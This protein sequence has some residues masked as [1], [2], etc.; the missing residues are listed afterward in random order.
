MDYL[1]F[2]PNSVVLTAMWLLILPLIRIIEDKLNYFDLKG[3]LSILWSL[4]I[5]AVLG[6]DFLTMDS[7]IIIKPDFVTTHPLHAVEFVM[8]SQLIMIG[9]LISSLFAAIMFYS[10]RYLRWE[11][12]LDDF[13][14]YKLYYYFLFFA[15]FLGFQVVLFSNDAFLLFVGWELMVVPGYALVAIRPSKSSAEAGIKYALI[16]SIGSIFMLY[17]ISLMY[18]ITGTFNIPMIAQA[19]QNNPALVN[20]LST[21]LAISFIIIGVGVTA[22]FIGFQTWIPDAYGAATSPVGAFVSGT[23]S[24][25]AMLALAKLLLSTLP[26]AKFHYSWILIIGGLSTMTV[27]NL[28]AIKQFGVRRILGY[29][30]IAQRGYLLFGLGLVAKIAEGT[31][32]SF[33][34]ADNG[35]GIIYLFGISFAY[36]EGTLFLIVGKVLY[37]A[38]TTIKSRDMRDL[39]GSLIKSPQT[40]LLMII[41]AL[42]LAGMPPTFGFVSK[43]LLVLTAGHS[44]I[45]NIFIAIFLLNSAVSI[46]YYLRIIRYLLFTQPEEELDMSKTPTSVNVAIALVAV[47]SILL[48]IFPSTLTSVF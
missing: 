18:Q 1:L 48:G 43:I 28:S 32:N 3:I 38:Q 12:L 42:G 35:L 47:V 20:D 17:G 21:W 16:S 15:A 6:Y 11:T 23:F 44:G 19:I 39:K 45:P 40:S 5:T 25:A 22:G 46:V 27:G 37:V 31:A 29:S 41:S 33:F 26:S 9:L 24:T 34:N 8:N 2:F 14:T 36:L 4:L 7:Q 30:S 10:W 13:G